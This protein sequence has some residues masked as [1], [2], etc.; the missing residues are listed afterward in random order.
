MTEPE[1]KSLTEQTLALPSELRHR[2]ANALLKS[3]DPPG[4]ELTPEEWHAAWMPE[5]RRRIAESDAGVPGVP[6]EEAWERIA[7]RH[8]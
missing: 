1:F 4:R 8:Q 6:L 2:L 7:G 5:I 3:F